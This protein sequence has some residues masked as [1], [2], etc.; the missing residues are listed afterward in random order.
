MAKFKIGINNEE[1]EIE[2][3]RQGN[4]FRVTRDGKT[5][6]LQLLHQ[7][8][9]HFLL[10]QQAAD[11]T[12]RR[13]RAAGHADGNKRAM[14]VNGRSFTYQKIEQQ[15]GTAVDNDSALSAAI[16]AVVADILVSE[17]D[18]VADGDKLILLESMKMV[19]PIQA[20]TDGIISSINCAI[21]DSVQPGVTLIE[22]E[23]EPVETIA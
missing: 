7:D 5:A 15:R 9:R 12:R 8:G 16:P 17:G 18:V 13:I 22:M 14:W 3:T 20:Q 4:A 10:E 1:V 23:T 19:I 6:D 21:G 2:V 11:G